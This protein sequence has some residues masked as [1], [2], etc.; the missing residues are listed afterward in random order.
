MYSSLLCVRG[1]IHS[2]RGVALQQTIYHVDADYSVAGLFSFLFFIGSRLSVL[3]FHAVIKRKDTWDV[4]RIITWLILCTRGTMIYIWEGVGWASNQSIG[5]SVLITPWWY[6]AVHGSIPHLILIKWLER[7]ISRIYTP[8]SEKCIESSLKRKGRT[9]NRRVKFQQLGNL[10]IPFT[11]P[12]STK[13]W[14]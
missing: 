14:Q 1:Y 13:S 11:A 6:L 12:F 8:G 9:I 5:T 10:P 3:P 7:S 4:S 2:L